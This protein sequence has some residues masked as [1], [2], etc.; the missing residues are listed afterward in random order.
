MSRPRIDPRE[1]LRSD[2]SPSGRPRISRQSN[3]RAVAESKE[4]PLPLRTVSDPEGTILVLVDANDGSLTDHD[5]DVIGAARQIAEPISHTVTVGVFGFAAD[6]RWD[7]AGADCVVLL[8]NKG[9]EAYAP[10]AHCQA[11]LRL[12]NKLMPK[13]VL[14][15]D[16][17]PG[18]GDVGRR[19]A[20]ETGRPLEASVH[21]ISSS[22]IIASADGGNSDFWVEE[23]FILLLEAECA[24]QVSGFRYPAVIE[25]DSEIAT[26]NFP[27]RIMDEGYLPC[28]LTNLALKES[29]FIVCAGNGVQDWES[30]KTLASK[31][32]G[33]IGCTRPV[34]D[35]G[36]LPKTRQIGASGELVTAK[37]YL[38]L[39]I[40]GAPQHMQGIAKC[41][42]VVAVNTNPYADMMG[43]ADLAIVADV[44]EVMPAL[45]T[46]L[47]CPGDKSP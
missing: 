1:V 15:P 38:A 24:P 17:N 14:M 33:T 29:E 43:R 40:S 19:L 45:I 22:Q 26:A 11:V 4:K 41:R 34:C 21:S 46:K 30:F 12:V 13:L 10:E 31:L 8:S 7:L 27:N 32:N 28:D 42:R 25:V 39:G 36:S 18:M 35:R 6:V 23:A 16:T 37:C 2:S 3:P 9:S 20:V 47:S 44:Q 5:L